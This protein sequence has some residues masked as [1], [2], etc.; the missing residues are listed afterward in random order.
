MATLRPQGGRNVDGEGAGGAV[1]AQESNGAEA[2][3]ERYRAAVDTLLAISEALGTNDPLNVR[4]QRCAQAIVDHFGTCSARVWEFDETDAVLQLSA[5]AGLSSDLHGPQS[6]IELGKDEIGRIAKERRAHVT[7]DVRSDAGIT[8]KAWAEHEA[9][10]S[11]AGLPLIVD[12]Q[13]VGVLAIFAKRMLDDPT[14]KVLGGICVQIA[15]AMQ[16]ESIETERGRFRQLF[17]GMLGHDLRNPLGAIAM[18]AQMLARS[19]DL[20]QH[21]RALERIC[22]ST[23]RMARMVTQL[24]DFAGANSLG[25]GIPIQRKEGDL[26]AIC[27]AVVDE[28]RPSYPEREIVE[29]YQ[30]EATA[31]WDV[32]RMAQVFSNLIENALS[33]GDPATPVSVSLSRRGDLLRGEVHNLGDAIPGE[34]VDDLFDPYRRV[35]STRTTKTK[36]LGIGLYITHQIIVSHGGTLFVVSSEASGTTFRFS[37]PVQR[38]DG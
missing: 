24:L 9:V 10:A 35:R 31:L 13:L 37:L 8:D 4:L 22:R 33:Y 29:T 34:V 32:D 17:L 14:L 1:E 26:H 11:F 18:S 5:S 7:N 21:T 3:G 25:S 36:G 19:G 16:R 30:H 20:P 12:G 23:D 27:R 28:L 15:L 38:G 6:H 2:G